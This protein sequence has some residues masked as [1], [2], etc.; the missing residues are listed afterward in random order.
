MHLLGNP[1]H[2]HFLA[3]IKFRNRVAF[4]DYLADEFVATDKVWWAFEVAAIEMKV[5]AAKSS[6]GDA[7]DGIGWMLELGI[8]A[9][10]NSNL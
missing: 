5:A 6:A 7:K 1:Y 2:Y 8:W 10:F 4:L 9:V 3:N